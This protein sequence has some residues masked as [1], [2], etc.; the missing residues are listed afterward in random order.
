MTRIMA[1]LNCTPDSFFSESR[2]QTINHAVERALQFVEEGAS[3]IDIGGMSTRPGSKPVELSVE[4]ERVLPVV[5]ALKS[6]IS[7]PLSIDTYRYEVAS[8]AIDLGIDFI[9]DITGFQDPRMQRLAK[10]ADVPIC[11]MHMQNI[12]E[13]MQDNPGYPKGVVEE[14]ID[15]FQKRLKPLYTLGLKPQNIYLDPGIGFGKSLDQNLKIL[16]D[17]D[18]LRELGHPLLLGT[19]RK[20]FIR[21]ITNRSAEESL[22]GTLGVNSLLIQKDVEILR[23]H[24]VR[25]HRDLIRVL[26]VLNQE[27]LNV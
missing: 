22:Y 11:L 3:Y 17:L 26:H 7:I 5:Q 1:I 9:N 27:R 20:S 25:A 6:E 19:S 15:F 16:Q 12:P 14:V 21:Q 8:K 2:A 23:V 10:D 4:L 24:D 18:K 13:N